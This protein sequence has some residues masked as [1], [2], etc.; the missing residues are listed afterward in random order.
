MSE[1]RNARGW[2]IP[3]EPIFAAAGENPNANEYAD[4]VGKTN[5][6]PSTVNADGSPKYATDGLTQDW[7]ANHPK[8]TE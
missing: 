1:R 4:N 2:A 8:P 7:W 3:P 5:A 6:T